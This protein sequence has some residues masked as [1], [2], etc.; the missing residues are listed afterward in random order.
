MAN[1]LNPSRTLSWGWEEDDY[2][3]QL[4]IFYDIK[5]KKNCLRTLRGIQNLNAEVT[6]VPKI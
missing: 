2:E 1:W 6:N 3:H 5:V 4:V